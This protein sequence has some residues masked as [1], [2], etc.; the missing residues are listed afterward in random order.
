MSITNLFK[1]SYYFNGSVD[2]TFQGFWIVVIVLTIILIT[3]FIAG[4]KIGRNKKLSGLYKNLY[5][6]WINLGYFVSILGLV[7]SFFRYQGISYFSWRLWPA[8]VVVWALVRI[9]Q[10][11]YFQKKVLPKKLAERD[12]QI[13][14]AK[15]FRSRR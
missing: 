1:I 6:Q 11:I 12:V 10:L 14:K 4:S 5:L 2:Y 13:S 9:G 7:F 8:L 3:S 15:Y